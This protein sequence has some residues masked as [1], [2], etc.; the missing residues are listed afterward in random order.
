MHYHLK[1]KSDPESRYDWRSVSLRIKPF[2]Q[3]TINPIVKFNSLQ[4]MGAIFEE[5]SG[6][7]FAR[8]HSI[9]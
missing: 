1:T 7:S 3:N 2:L 6:L 9:F 5:T 8:R 4:S